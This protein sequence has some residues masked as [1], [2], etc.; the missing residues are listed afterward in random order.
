MHY[1]HDIELALLG[2]VIFHDDFVKVS[3]IVEPKHFHRKEHGTV[4]EIYRELFISQRESPDVIDVLQACK[5]KMGENYGPIVTQA[6]SLAHE[7]WNAAE[8]AELVRS[9]WMRREMQKLGKKLETSPESA[10]ELLGEAVTDLLSLQGVKEKKQTVDAAT[11]AQ[12]T[13]QKLRAAVE[14]MRSGEGLPDAVYLGYPEL[15]QMIGGILPLEHEI[16]IV[17]GR[18]NM[19]KTTLVL[20]FAR[21]MAQA[22]TAILFYSFDMAQSKVLSN[23]ACSI[24]EIDHSKV[25]AANLSDSELARMDHAFKQL[26]GLNISFNEHANRLDQFALSAKQ[27]RLRNPNTPGVIIIDYAQLMSVSN[28]SASDTYATTTYVSKQMKAIAKDLD[29]CIMPLAQL[30]RSVESTADKRPVLSHLKES[31]ELEQVAQTVLMVYRP[32]YYKFQTDEEG[33]STQGLCEVI[34]AKN[35]NNVTGSVKLQFVGKYQ[36]FR[37]WAG[38]VNTHLGTMGID[39]NNSNGYVGF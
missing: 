31:G 8:K 28:I 16:V 34:I 7:A 1:N 5:G 2:R 35:R 27:W 33:N 3:D 14:C 24:A 12:E 13:Q 38:P 15:D 10:D 4:F 37:E 11:L 17:G 29:I 36:Q 9:M 30:N 25:R 23:M 32:E 6:Q 21:N 19:G 26:S 18:P 39:M 22:G 20:N